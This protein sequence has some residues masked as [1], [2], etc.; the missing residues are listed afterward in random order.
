MF[1]A[2][3]VATGQ[4][5]EKRH[6]RHRSREFLRFPDTINRTVP[7]PPDVH[8]ILDNYGTPTTRRLRHHLA[9]HPVS[10]T[11][12]AHHSSWL[13]LLE[14]MFSTLTKKQITRNPHCSTRPLDAAIA[15]YLRIRNEAQTPFVWNKTAD[16][17]LSKVPGFCQRIPTS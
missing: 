12:H 4:V 9:A 10:R 15:E 2:L 6:R 5:I 3:D 17:P 14:R 11:L 1:A 16:E 13:N 7:A 8:L